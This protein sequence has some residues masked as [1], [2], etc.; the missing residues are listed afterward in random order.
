[1]WLP[2]VKCYICSSQKLAKFLDLG[3]HPPPLNFV[4]KEEVG[5]K[6]Q[7]FPLQIFFCESCGLVQLGNAVEP[8][9]MFKNYLYTSGISIAFKNHLDSL[10]KLLV[11]RFKMTADDLV[12]DIASNDGTLLACFSKYGVR[13]LGVEP[14]NTAKIAQENRIP[15]VNEF[16]DEKV[17]KVIFKKSGKAKI[18]TATNVFAHVKDLDSFMKGIKLLLAENGAFVSESQYL[19]D[20]IEKLEYD[21]IY[22]EH[23]RYYGLKQIIQLLGLY[24]MEVFDAEHISSHGGSI[25]V[26]ASHKGTFPISKSVQQMLK[27]ED[28]LKLSS[29]E[30]YKAFAERVAENRQKLRTIL[31]KLKSKGKKI[32]GLSAPA[33]SST[34]LNYCG[35]NSD[36][37]DYIAEK[38]DLKIG[39]F[40]P[41]THIKVV[42]DKILV[43]EQPDYAL[44]LSWHLGQSVVSKIRN[45]GYKGKIIVP[46]PEPIIV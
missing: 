5:K 37:L 42:D 40:T 6:D 7:A 36:I 41:G 9:I 44:L 20:I 1:M 38:S 30:T 35:I 27:K 16:F 17:A 13:I 12:I 14:S 26:Y 46:L 19:V 32:V 31:L 25:R 4:T 24:D 21:T 45:D 11:A 29:F 33:R 3:D 28:D 23:L 8:K 2:I 15:T 10:A 22:H 18:I 34:I 39:K 43:D